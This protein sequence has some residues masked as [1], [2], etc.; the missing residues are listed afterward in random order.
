VALYE[1]DATLVMDPSGQVIT[2]RDAIRE[3][4]RP[5]L[6]AN[7]QMTCE[8]TALRSADGDLAMTGG[9]WKMTGIDADGN[10]VALS[11]NS[12]EVVR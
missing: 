11:G 5:A 10:R 3:F 8:T 2:G 1:P 12:R 9:R 7:L 6:A 4:I